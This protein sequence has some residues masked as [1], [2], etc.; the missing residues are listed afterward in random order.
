MGVQCPSCGLYLRDCV[1]SCANGIITVKPGWFGLTRDD[2]TTTSVFQCKQQLACNGTAC[3]AG[4]IGPLCGV[5]DEGY[6]QDSRGECTKCE[7]TTTAFG[8]LTLVA[9]LL[10]LEILYANFDKWYDSVATVKAIVDLARDLELQAISKVLVATMQI[11]SN[12]AKVLNVPFPEAFRALLKLLSVFRFDISLML[13][14]GCFYRNSYFASLFVSF[15]VV[16]VVALF[17]G[18]SYLRSISQSRGERHLREL[19]ATFDEGGDGI[20]ADEIVAM[21]DK[22]SLTTPRAEIE[23][24]FAQADTDKNGRMSFEEFCNAFESSLGIGM[25]L[26]K[27]RLAKARNDSLGRLFLLV[28][29]LYPGLT[30]K[31]FEIFLCRDLG[32]NT[33]PPS[34][35]HADYGVDCG[36]SYSMRWTVGGM[37]VILWPA[38]VPAGLFALM[39][40]VRKELRAGD[41]AA[42]GMFNFLIGDYKPEFW[43]WEVVELLRKLML[44]GILSLVG[45][46][47]IAQAT[48][49]TT[50]TFVFFALHLRVMPYK[51]VTLNFTKAVSEVQLFVVLL[52]S[53][54]LQS[55][56]VGFDGEA[57]TIEDYGLIQ[58]V[59]T[60]MIAPVVICLI[61]YNAKQLHERPADAIVKSQLQM[62]ENPLGTEG[63]IETPMNLE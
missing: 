53:V 11:I 51:S 44:S 10:L 61:V 40:R 60:I 36:E 57:V 20:T 27:A 38:A 43:Y 21:A 13:G 8:V 45:R 48:L 23:T 32:P 34:V 52:M 50:I 59:F 58:T 42:T 29:L 31:V 46:G 19:F 47:S 37:L 6:N 35:L 54:L 33:S 26:E 55:H 12:F 49:G 24:M 30:N 39:F 18:A 4:Y 56:S 28:F 62:T 17:V 15:A 63:Q 3:T 25:F 9:L 41:E 22:V 2:G 5:C 1:T 14:I 7:E 16:G